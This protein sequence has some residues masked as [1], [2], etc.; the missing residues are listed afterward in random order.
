MSV[1]MVTLIKVMK[2]ASFC[3]KPKCSGLAF[4]LG[5]LLC[6]TLSAKRS[7]KRKEMYVPVFETKK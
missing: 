4:W 7:K 2:N 1:I 3:Q 6:N 5:W